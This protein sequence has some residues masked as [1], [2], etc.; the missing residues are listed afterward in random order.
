MKEKLQSTEDGLMKSID[1]PSY[2]LKAQ[3]EKWG[4][5]INPRL[6]VSDENGN[7]AVDSKSF[8]TTM[9]NFRTFVKKQPLSTPAV[10]LQWCAY[11]YEVAI[12]K[13]EGQNVSISDVDYVYSS[14]CAQYIKG[15]GANWSNV[16]EEIKDKIKV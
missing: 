15:F 11:I 8:H 7:V 12:Q 13:Y 5:E 1:S 9:H 4:V 3:I 6:I 2:N 14:N 10:L 16:D